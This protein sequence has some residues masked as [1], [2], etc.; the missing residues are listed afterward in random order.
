MN[1]IKYIHAFGTSFTAGGGYEF[2][3]GGKREK[4]HK[5]YNH[6]DE[7]LTRYNFSWPGQLN[8]LVKSHGIIVYNHA[9]SGYGNQRM[10]R[11]LDEVVNSPTFKKEEHLFLLEFS[12][13]GRQELFFTPLNDYIIFN[14]KENDPHNKDWSGAAHRYFYDDPKT[15][16]LLND[17]MKLI[18]DYHELVYSLESREEEM[19]RN[20]T[21]FLHYLESLELNYLLGQHPY[22]PP[23]KYKN[24]IDFDLLHKH[25]IKFDDEMTLGLN[26]YYQNNDFTITNE[27]Y[28]VFND[29]HSSLLGAKNIAIKVFNSL[30]LYN[31][32]NDSELDVLPSD[33]KFCIKEIAT[34]IKSKDLF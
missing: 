14:F 32:L 16:S 1:K 9:E 31:Y 18:Y 19:R 34:E 3:A 2:T 15:Q 10:Y 33:T 27:T 30:I 12:G 20:N 4:L 13:V 26:T 24:E 23:R 8:K 11:M 7:E 28:G 21:F 25:T 29:G 6:L 22:T 17:N 5:L